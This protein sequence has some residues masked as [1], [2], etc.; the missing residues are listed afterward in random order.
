MKRCNSPDPGHL[1][2]AGKQRK[3]G[4]NIRICGLLLAAVHDRPAQDRES[5]DI[6]TI[7]KS[8]EAKLEIY[9]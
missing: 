9:L 4:R 5:S 3:S 1:E 2:F 8:L 7:G 6:V